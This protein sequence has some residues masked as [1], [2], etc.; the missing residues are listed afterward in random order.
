VLAQHHLADLRHRWCSA[1][2]LSSNSVLRRMGRI[3]DRP[4]QLIATNSRSR[5]RLR[6]SDR[7]RAPAEC[8]ETN[9]YVLRARMLRLDGLTVCALTHATI[10]RCYKLPLPTNGRGHVFGRDTLTV[11]APVQE[12]EQHQ[13]HRR[14]GR[15]AGT[16]ARSLC[17]H[18]AETALCHAVRADVV[19]MAVA[20][21]SFD[22][23]APV[24]ELNSLM[25]AWRP[26]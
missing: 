14:T 24:E 22:V 12:A 13:G 4:G 15:L 7:S 21:W 18:R 19:A 17:A 26:T 20:S 5:D 11:W 8:V 3:A 16:N 2:V 1:R 10:F 6:G 25:H 9:P 23:S